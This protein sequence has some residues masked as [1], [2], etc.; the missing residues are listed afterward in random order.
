[1]SCA[2]ALRVQL[3]FPNNDLLPAERYDQIFT[4]HG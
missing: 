2:L 1:L 4:I 3:A